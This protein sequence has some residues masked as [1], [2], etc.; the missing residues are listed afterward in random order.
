MN[1]ERGFA[2]IAYEPILVTRNLMRG[3]LDNAVKPRL[4]SNLPKLSLVMAIR[5]FH[6]NTCK[7]E[8]DAFN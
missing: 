7:P 3:F 5:K 1:P 4:G 6:D 2:K 8:L